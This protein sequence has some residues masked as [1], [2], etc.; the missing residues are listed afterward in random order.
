M[1]TFAIPIQQSTRS[2]A[3]VVRQE[4]ERKGRQIRKEEVHNLCSQVKRSY[5][6]KLPKIPQKNC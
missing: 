4:K 2:L 5:L 1:P 6:Q 3:R